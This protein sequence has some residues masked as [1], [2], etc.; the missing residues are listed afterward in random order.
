MLKAVLWDLDGTLV[1][2]AEFHW[3][4]W[5]DVMAEEGLPITHEQFVQSFG[6]R[7][8]LI[9]SGWLGEGADPERTRRLSE[10]K[11]SRFR[12]LVR[13]HGIE[14]LPGVRQWVARLH[15]EGWVHAI[16]TSAPRANLEALADAM[17]MREFFLAGVAAEDVTHGK[18]D[19]E[20]FLLAAARLGAEPH[21]SIVVED[22]PTGIEAGRR[23]GM[24]TIG[25]SLLHTLPAADIYVSTLPD[26]PPDTF[27]RL[28]AMGSGLFA[29][30][31]REK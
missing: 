15:G 8:D 12:A 17:G 23:A 22:A 16:A 20:V 6:K 25:V 5:R 18:P 30:R 11:E 3:R 24:R 28:L 21:Q 4:A 2:S 31:H 9:L 19:P 26:L 13:A 1:D 29:D 14:P 10:E 27:T 7:N